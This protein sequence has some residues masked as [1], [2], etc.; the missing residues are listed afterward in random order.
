MWISDRLETLKKQTT[1]FPGLGLEIPG[2]LG[3]RHSISLSASVLEFPQET[4][5]VVTLFLEEKQ[6]GFR[7]KMLSVL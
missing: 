6:A 1:L 5:K 2:S 7:E 4:R 3:L